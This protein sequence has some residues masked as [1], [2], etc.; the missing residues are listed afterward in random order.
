MKLL[1]KGKQFDLERELNV[2]VSD[3]PFPRAVVSVDVECDRS[4]KRVYID[5]VL[6]DDMK[7][8]NE[9]FNQL[10]K[11]TTISVSWFD[12]SFERTVATM[13][14]DGLVFQGHQLDFDTTEAGPQ[15]FSVAFESV[16]PS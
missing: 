2:V 1:P 6:N 8:L 9:V 10:A 7:D 4:C 3:V 14:Y 16:E 13:V 11:V 15:Y 5:Y 12:L